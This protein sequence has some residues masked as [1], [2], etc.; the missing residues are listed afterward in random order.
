M[1]AVPTTDTGVAREHALGPVAEIPAGE[2]R[3]YTVRGEQIAVFRLRDGQVR[4]TQA[5]CP[6]RG[7]P[8]AD[9][10]LDDQVVVCPLHAYAY[11]L[12]TGR[13]VGDSDDRAA[14]VDGKAQGV[15]AQTGEPEVGGA[16]ATAI[17][18]YP[19]R[20]DGSGTVM[21]TVGA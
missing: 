9:G 11:V 14:H 17:R 8:L 19:A 5:E 6:H 20:V 15:G 13:R 18:V 1:T 16:P 2:G 3:C 10:Q 4:A 7:G 12:A 21:V